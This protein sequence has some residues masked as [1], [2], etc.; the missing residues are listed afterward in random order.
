MSQ[1]LKESQTTPRREAVD[2]SPEAI[3]ARLEDVRQLYRL[4]LYL[5]QAKKL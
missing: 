5:A 2:M 3:A 4:C 1:S